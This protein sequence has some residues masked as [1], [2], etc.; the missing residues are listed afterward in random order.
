[1]QNAD[2]SIITLNTRGLY[3]PSKRYATYSYI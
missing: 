1:M 3:T 2:V